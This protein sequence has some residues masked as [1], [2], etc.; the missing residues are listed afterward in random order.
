[1]EKPLRILAVADVPED[2]NAG[3]AGAEYETF[4]ALRALGHEVDAVWADGVGRRIRHGNLNLLLELPR[5]YEAVVAKRLSAAPYD[6]VHVN[7]PH[8]YRAARLVQ[9]RWPRSVFIHR[10][11]GWEPRVAEVLAPWRRIYGRD[12]KTPWRRAASDV[13]ASLLARHAAQ[14]VRWADGHI[15]CST[16]D[17]EYMRER[18]GVPADKVRML[19]QSAPEA[20]LA[21]PPAPFDDARR[22][23]VLFVGQYVFFKAPML[24]AAAM[25][26]IAEA[27]PDVRF[28]WVAGRGHHADI[29]ALLS[30]R[31]RERLALHDWMPQAALRDVYDSAGIFLFPSFFEGSGKVHIEALSRGLCVV[32]S[33]AGGMRD[34]VEDGRSGVLITPGDAGE[35]A[36]EALALIGDAERAR[37]M[38]AAAAARARQFSWH[39]TAVETAAFYRDR[40]GAKNGR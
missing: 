30:E 4:V 9:R 8:G 36:R 10:S 34:Y 7:Q 40:L 38:S 13:L 16:E 17:A 5:R 33:R 11:H 28:S 27:R 32:A 15:V 12:R 23:H 24:V 21:T 3:A 18:N 25:N 35:L 31:V 26:A 39:R 20:F 2:P 1:M 6:V 14:I 29:R 22:R 19:P 37:A